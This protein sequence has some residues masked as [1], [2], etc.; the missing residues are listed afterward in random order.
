MNTH[1]E[2]WRHETEARLVASW[3]YAKRENYLRGVADKR[4]VNAATALRSKLGLE[5]MRKK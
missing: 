1:S 4:G 3:P 2:S 5:M